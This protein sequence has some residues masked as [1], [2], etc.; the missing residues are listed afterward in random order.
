MMTHPYRLDVSA[1]AI[2]IA[3]SADAGEDP[4]EGGAVIPGGYAPVVVRQGR[5]RRL[6]P[7]QWGVPP[8]PR[9]TQP[10]THLRN[11]ESPFW[12]GT[13]RHTQFRCLV[14]AT[15]FRAG[16]GWLAVPGA[17]VFAFAG[18]WRDSEVPSFAIVSVDG[19]LGGMA[20]IPLIL[21]A[22][23]WQAW[24]SEDWKTVRR[25]LTLGHSP[26]DLDQA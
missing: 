12:I 6:I 21:P 18:I 20:S 14:P 13:L 3:L 25:L 9:G 10:V 8:P 15:A 7:R 11:C 23:H 1:A 24:L 17:P 5:G 16:R 4:W 22:A 19:S 26:L 2:G